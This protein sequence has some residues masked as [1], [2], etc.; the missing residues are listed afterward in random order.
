MMLKIISVQNN[1]I[2]NDFI[3]TLLPRYKNDEE[4]FYRITN[5][6][7]VK[8]QRMDQYF[9]KIGPFRGVVVYRNIADDI[10]EDMFVCKFRNDHNFANL[11]CKANGYTMGIYI[12]AM[13]LFRKS[14]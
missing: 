13:C 11:M 3:V 12:Q 1:Y 8:M 14:Y 9:S 7:Y 6:I 2:R 4:K 10:A 5:A